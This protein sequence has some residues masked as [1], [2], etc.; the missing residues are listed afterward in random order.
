[1]AISADQIRELHGYEVRALLVVVPVL[2]V[3]ERVATE[4]RELHL[5][6]V[7]RDKPEASAGH[8]LAGFTVPQ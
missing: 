5:A 7:H 2:D 3:L 8:Q 4:A 6:A 1:M